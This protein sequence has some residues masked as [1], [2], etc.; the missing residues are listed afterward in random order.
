[1]PPASLPTRASPGKAPPSTPGLP[2]DLNSSKFCAAWS[3]PASK[4]HL[5][6]VS[7]SAYLVLLGASRMFLCPSWSTWKSSWS[8][9]DR[10]LLF[11]V[12]SPKSSRASFL[13]LAPPT[14]LCSSAAFF[15]GPISMCTYLLLWADWNSLRTELSLVSVEVLCAA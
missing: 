7:F 1:M 5:Q 4:S 13:F 8:P 11:L 15:I 6:A 9:P 2:L 10:L 3:S 14:T 12:M